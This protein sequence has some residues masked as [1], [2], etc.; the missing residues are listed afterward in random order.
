MVHSG[1]IYVSE[2]GP[3]R[4]F[5]ILNVGSIKARVQE[6]SKNVHAGGFYA[7]PHPP[8][9]MTICSV[10]RL[11]YNHRY[12]RLWMKD[13]DPADLSCYDIGFISIAFLL[14]AICLFISYYGEHT[15]V[16]QD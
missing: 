10:E 1:Q 14:T 15:I 11:S 12:F 4:F 13:T 16:E 2:A 5:Q 9:W 3:L 8:F 7:S 6:V